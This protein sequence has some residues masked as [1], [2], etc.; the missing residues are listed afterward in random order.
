LAVGPFA[1]AGRRLLILGEAEAVFV[2][3]IAENAGKASA[4]GNREINRQDTMRR[5]AF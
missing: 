3:V 1:P 2:L 5:G 4:V